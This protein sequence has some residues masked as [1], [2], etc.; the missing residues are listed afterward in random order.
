M[1]PF[2]RYVLLGTFFLSISSSLLFATPQEQE[3]K[4]QRFHKLAT[5]PS[6]Q[7]FFEEA[8]K[9]IRQNQLIAEVDKAE[10]IY[11]FLSQDNQIEWPLEELIKIAITK[12]LSLRCPTKEIPGP[13]FELIKASPYLSTLR[14]ELSTRTEAELQNA[15]LLINQATHIQELNLSDNQL[16]NKD[17]QKFKTALQEQ[18]HLTSLNVSHNLL[19]EAS[20]GVTLGYL[21]Q[22]NTSLRCLNLAHNNLGEED[23]TVWALVEGISESQTLTELDLSHNSFSNES[24]KVLTK[25]LGGHPSLLSLNISNTTLTDRALCKLNQALSTN[26]TLTTLDLSFNHLNEWGATHIGWMLSLNT[27][28]VNLNLQGNQI[29][30][31]GAL[32]IISALSEQSL[33][34]NI[35]LRENNLNLETINIHADDSAFSHKILWQPQREKLSPPP[36]IQNEAFFASESVSQ[37]VASVEKP[38]F[39]TSTK[40]FIHPLIIRLERGEKSIKWHQPLSLFNAKKISKAL[41]KN[42]SLTLL[43]IASSQ[44]HDAEFVELIK[45]LSSHP[46]ITTLNAKG[47]HLTDWSAYML[48]WLANNNSNLKEIEFSE[49]KI[50]KKGEEAIISAL[51]LEQVY[52]N[53]SMPEDPLDLDEDQ[54]LMMR[55]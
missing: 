8:S 17:L 22:V 26:T 53:T 30:N 5:V 25:V 50:T 37:D 48:A 46:Q 29:Q 3:I 15:A 43:D 24:F 6:L 44:L 52:S 7:P 27:T 39:P 45:G 51:Q 33:S 36:L 9:S 28:L 14:L 19:H 40:E 1:N 2:L 47:N 54:E 11:S 4:E 16:K 23:K 12:S 10:G 41:K 55:L 32:R 13:I 49:N 31:G 18:T 38:V 42:T 21:L 35:D 34:R 20:V